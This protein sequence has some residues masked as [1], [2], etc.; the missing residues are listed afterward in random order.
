MSPFRLPKLITSFAAGLLLLCPFPAEEATNSRQPEKDPVSANTDSNITLEDWGSFGS[1][2][3]G[4]SEP[5]EGYPGVELFAG[6]KKFAK[7]GDKD[8]FHGVLPNGRIVKPADDSTQVGMNPLGIVL[9]PDRK[10]IIISQP[11]QPKHSLYPHDIF[12]S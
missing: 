1:P 7:T 4:T 9:T 12:V 11:H 2:V 3:I 10:F 5:T 6:P 8:Y